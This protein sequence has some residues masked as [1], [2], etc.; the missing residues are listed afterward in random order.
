MLW[1]N[2]TDIFSKILI[3]YDAKVDGVE[4]CKRIK[5]NIHTSHIPVIL[6]TARASNEFILSGYEA[7]AD[8]YI[9]KP[10]NFDI[11]LLRIRKLIEQQEVRK[12]QFKA[13]IEI[14]P[15]DIT[16]TSLDK[17]LIQKAIQSTERNMSNT[18]YSGWCH[19]LSGW[20]ISICSCFIII[21][22]D[23][24]P[25]HIIVYLFIFWK[26]DRFPVQP[27][28]VCPEIK[29]FTLYFPGSVPAD[30]VFVRRN[31]FWV[32]SPIVRVVLIGNAFNSF[33][34]VK[35]SVT[36]QILPLQKNIE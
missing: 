22:F 34:S 13:S 21:F 24:H 5:T 19:K 4:L 10:F 11:L 30:S 17:K 31:I 12:S 29:V 36:T 2:L 35:K 23:I 7:G 32:R 20:I 8:E 15:T 33:Q 28:Q 18:E 16:I 14:K 9:S 3:Y 6:L 26:T 1:D 27:F 25:Y